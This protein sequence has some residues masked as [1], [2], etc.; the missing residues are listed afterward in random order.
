MR[1]FVDDVNIRWN[2]WY[3]VW[4]D[5]LATIRVMAEAG[6]MFNLKKCKLC[7]PK[8]VVLGHVLYDSTYQLANKCLKKLI[9]QS[10]PRSLHDLQI[11]LGKLFW[12]N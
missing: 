8:C 3:G 5:T 11:V 1:A 9:F 7:V 6:L 12:V 2:T 4:E 10:L